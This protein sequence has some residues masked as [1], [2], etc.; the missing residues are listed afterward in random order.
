MLSIRIATRRLVAELREL[1][2]MPP[3]W[4]S[5]L[6]F[7]CLLTGYYV[8]R[9]VRDAMGA[10]SEV[11]AVFP[12]GVVEW[13]AERGIA[14]GEFTLQVLFTLTFL[15]MLVIQP[16]YGALVSRYAR[17][18]FLPVIYLFFIA[19]LVGFYFIF[20]SGMSGRGVLFFVWVAVFNLFAVTV[21]WSF[22][23]DVFDNVQA[24]RI[25]GYIGAAG[26]IGAVTGPSI[27]RLLAERIGTANLLLISAALLGL[28]L[29]CIIR[30]RWWARQ[31]ERERGE[32]G[33]QDFAMGGGV[34]A[35]IRLAFR[36]PV[37]RAFA[38][39]MFFG[40][41]VGTLLY[42]EQAAIAQR[43]Y[44]D[45]DAR[46]AFYA[47][48]DLAINIVSLSIQL[49]L[50]RSLLNHLGVARVLLLPP[51]AILAGFALLT[52]S[53]VPAMVAL[54]QIV[55]RAGEF[56]IGKPARETIYTRVSPELRYKS[57]A[58]IDTVVYR[59]GDLSFVWLHKLLAM[60]GSTVVF[61][62][63]IVTALGM[64]YGAWRLGRTQAAL[65]EGRNPETGTATAAAT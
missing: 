14:L 11:A 10:T 3:L 37:M 54:V 34:L 41:G 43:F 58:M 19:C 7:F 6:Y 2:S 52:A 61:G 8:L 1:L 32:R 49:L 31:R 18:V 33:G 46:T 59:G 29:F 65:P 42:N 27:T 44:P 62:A 26:T 20:D 12:A 60:G 38:I 15:V 16:A 13:F 55:T 50:T 56:S 30:L 48:I 25:Y 23:S 51:L 39:L 40:V 64:G 17:R 28:C 21:F 36:E 53:P 4:W 47:G 5:A 35:G 9:P 22:M 45:S 57:K 63:G 24:K